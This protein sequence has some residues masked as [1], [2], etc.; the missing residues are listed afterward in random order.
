[1]ITAC[2]LL[3]FGKLRPD[4]C[5]LSD[6]VRR[7]ARLGQVLDGSL[8]E[9]YVLEKETFRFPR[10]NRG[11]RENLGYTERELHDLRAI[12]IK[13][14]FDGESLR[15]LVRALLDGS[16]EVLRFQT[17]H[18]RK[19]GS[20]YPVEVNLQVSRNTAPRSSSLSWWIS[21]SASVSKQSAT[22][23]SFPCSRRRRHCCARRGHARPVGQ[24]AIR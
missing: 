13:P 10:V 19:D 12:S 23:W 8:S 18:L 15:A 17:R 2:L 14:E 11:A 5:S 22:V 4:L 20:R 1:M 7:E 24:R 3:G 21:L 9:P 6:S 16:L